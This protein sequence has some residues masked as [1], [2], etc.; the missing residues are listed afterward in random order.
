MQ[1]FSKLRK[2]Y[3]MSIKLSLGLFVCL[4]AGALAAKDDEA[5]QISLDG[6]FADTRAAIIREVDRGDL[7]REMTDAQR[8]SLFAELDQIA[9][10]MG[11][12]SSP[13]QGDQA[14][15]QR[16]QNSVN[17]LLAQVAE[18]SKLVCRRERGL[19]SNIPTR[20]CQTVA[21]RRRQEAA[22]REEI[23]RQQVSPGGLGG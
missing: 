22:A 12:S 14:V 21:A 20:V 3:G 7:Y 4:W 9:A 8:K 16:L 18:D 5:H 6:G 23:S 2:V 15:L 17:A 10:L 1:Q 19:G 13:S 11:A